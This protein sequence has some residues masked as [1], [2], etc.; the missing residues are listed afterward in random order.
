MAT[1]RVTFT[2]QMDKIVNIEIK[3]GERLDEKIDKVWDETDERTG[4]YVPF[5]MKVHIQELD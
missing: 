2:Y 3:D 5:S 1:Y 4:D